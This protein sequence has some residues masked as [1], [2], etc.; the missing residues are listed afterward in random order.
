MKK[1]LRYVVLILLSFI[2]IGSITY[3][4]QVKCSSVISIKDMVNQIEHGRP[5]NGYVYGEE[6]ETFLRIFSIDIS[7][8]VRNDNDYVNNNQID[9]IADGKEVISVSKYRL[10]N[11]P[12]TILYRFNEG[13]LSAVEYILDWKRLDE[14]AQLDLY[15]DLKNEML[16][17][18][19]EPFSSEI[20]NKIFLMENTHWHKKNSLNEQVT[21]VLLH[22]SVD[23]AT[24]NYIVKI[25]IGII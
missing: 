9:I 24:G 2:T 20:S 15:H 23:S 3:I 5:F 10:K 12:L 14:K 11:Q 17:E 4:I 1:W 25:E 19:G 13:K 6:W 7:E 21:D 8:T 16:A 18:L 22:I